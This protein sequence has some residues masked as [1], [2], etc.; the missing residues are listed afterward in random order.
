MPG[1]IS[2]R[3]HSSARD[4]A[5]SQGQ[6]Q[7]GGQERLARWRLEDRGQAPG[8]V[9]V[10]GLQGRHETEGCGIRL[11][12]PAAFSLAQGGLEAG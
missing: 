9:Q 5:R 8:P 3:T 6:V 4:W 12:E 10:T 1:A 7:V 2:D 11:Q